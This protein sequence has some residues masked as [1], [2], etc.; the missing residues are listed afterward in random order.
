MI[1]AT[2]IYNAVRQLIKK[3]GR[4]GFFTL[5]EFNKWSPIVEG[6]L[7]TYCCKFDEVESEIKDSLS[8]FTTSAALPIV[9]GFV[10][11]PADYRKVKEVGYSLHINPSSCG[12]TPTTGTFPIDYYNGNEWNYML[13]SAIRKGSLSKRRFRYRQFGQK[14]EISEKHGSIVLDYV[15]NPIYAN[16]SYTINP[17]LEEWV[18]DENLTT[19]FEWA[20]KDR[21]NLIDL[22]CVFLGISIR[23]TPLI[24]FAKM[25]KM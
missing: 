1:L 24:E 9:S 7:M 10:D 20:E 3:D 21:Q 17:A 14:F 23:E 4:T 6:V 18:I 11:L 8:P 5:D 2:S 22:F 12:G 16:I 19:N 15:R 25:A 13:T